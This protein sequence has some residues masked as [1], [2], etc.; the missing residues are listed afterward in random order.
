MLKEKII[1][2]KKLSM[3]EDICRCN[4]NEE[5]MTRQNDDKCDEFKQ[6][7]VEMNHEK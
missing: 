2:D 5:D 1:K 3:T 7:D 4:D 6:N